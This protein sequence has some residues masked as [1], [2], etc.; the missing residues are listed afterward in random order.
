MLSAAAV[1]ETENENVSVMPAM[2]A[3]PKNSAH[4]DH[5]KAASVP[6]ETSVSIVAAP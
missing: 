2:P 3:L 6:T 1:R 5:A 4:S